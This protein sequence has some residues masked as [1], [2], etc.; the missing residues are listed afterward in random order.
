MP[1]INSKLIKKLPEN[2]IVFNMC[3]DVAF[4]YSCANICDKSND[5]TGFFYFVSLFNFTERMDFLLIKK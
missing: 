1:P 4:K 2:N 3:N 5:I